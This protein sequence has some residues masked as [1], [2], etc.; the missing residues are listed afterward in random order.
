MS[1]HHCTPGPRLLP[2]LACLLRLFY[3][4]RCIALNPKDAARRWA[5]LGYVSALVCKLE[6]LQTTLQSARVIARARAESLRTCWRTISTVGPGD[7][8]GSEIWEVQTPFPP[9]ASQLVALG[10]E[11]PTPAKHGPMV[12]HIGT[13]MIRQ[14]A[15]N[16]KEAVAS[17]QAEPRSAGSKLAGSSDVCGGVSK[18]PIL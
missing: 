11:R 18:L 17:T 15:Q 9:A 1:P 3:F 7:H 4:I 10:A 14:A 2:T 8:T 6:A 12:S 13:M 16:R 5:V